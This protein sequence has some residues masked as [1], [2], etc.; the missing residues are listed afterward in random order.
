MKNFSLLIKSIL[1]S[2]IKVGNTKNVRRKTIAALITSFVV[3][4]FFGIIYSLYIYSTIL[5]FNENKYDY[6]KGN[7]ISNIFAVTS[8]LSIFLLVI[9]VYN[10]AIY[11]KSE[12]LLIF[13]IKGNKLFFSKIVVGSLTFISFFLFPLVMNTFV[14][15]GLSS[16]SVKLNI[17][18]YI[19]STIF[20]LSNVVFYFTLISFILI[21]FESFTHFSTNKIFA[22]VFM[23]IFAIL[24]GLVFVYFMRLSSFSSNGKIDVSYIDSQLD[25]YQFLAPMGYLHK[26]TILLSKPFSYAIMPL[27][28]VAD[29]LLIF[30]LDLYTK[31]KYLSLL[32]YKNKEFNFLK[33]FSK[34][35]NDIQKEEDKIL[36]D[37]KKKN[38]KYQTTFAELK[39]ELRLFLP[40]LL[41]SI[42]SSVISLGA[43]IAIVTLATTDNI[44]NFLPENLKYFLIGYLSI[45]GI[46]YPQITYNAYGLEG[47]NIY[48]LMSFPSKKLNIFKNKFLAL[49]IL[50]LPFALFFSILVSALFKVEYYYYF[51][52]IFLSISYLFSVTALN[53]FLGL[54]K[55]NMNVTRNELM[56]QNPTFILVEILNIIYPGIYLLL[57]ISMLYY[58]FLYYIIP[59]V[60]S[61][62]YIGLGCLFL[63]YGKE[64]F[65]QLMKGR[66]NL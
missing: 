53:Y 6:L 31:K 62:I 44:N 13:P 18:S 19:S 23:S 43:L 39:R 22:N 56:N 9:L 26:E 17:Y 27:S 1:Y 40:S 11:N 16:S 66:K 10:Y 51:I 42:L 30:L 21:F 36:K 7:Y 48:M 3:Y 57:S 5:V 14:L 50:Y 52:Y 59:L 58:D 34:K 41:L 61:I 45:T 49:N 32:V 2:N 60:S 12:N 35:K 4:L 63:Y 33:M 64:Q 25:K 54:I 20:S 8:L 24:A 46:C 47:N 28:I 65:D 37:E 15:V 29:V 55:P 38:K